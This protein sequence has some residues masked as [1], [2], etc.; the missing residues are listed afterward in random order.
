M[1]GPPARTVPAHVPARMCPGIDVLDACGALHLAGRPQRFVPGVQAGPAAGAGPQR[2]GFA[3]AG[4]EPV[5]QVG[6]LFAAAVSPSTAAQGRHWKRS[7]CWTFAGMV[8]PAYH[9]WYQD[10]I[11]M[12]GGWRLAGTGSSLSPPPR[13]APAGGAAARPR[14]ARPAIRSRPWPG[15]GRPARPRRHRPGHRAPRPAA[16]RPSRRSRRWR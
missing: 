12:Q 4:G 2:C 3:Q 14:P 6:L 15:P 5:L 9:Q 1:P 16:V 10:C 11:R 7:E 8:A 13:A